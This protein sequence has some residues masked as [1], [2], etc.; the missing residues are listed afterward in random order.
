MDDR[1]RGKVSFAEVEEISWR[2]RRRLMLD[3]L[4]SLVRRGK[5]RNPRAVVS[6]IVNDPQYSLVTRRER[7]RRRAVN[8]RARQS[9]KINRK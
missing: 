1:T 8:Y 3:T 6:K 5:I 7:E 2:R 9:R 4:T